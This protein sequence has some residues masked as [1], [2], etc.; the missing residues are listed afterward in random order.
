MGG[1][2]QDILIHFFV[3]NWTNQ[4]SELT[5]SYKPGLF[6]L[7][8]SVVSLL[9][10]IIPLISL[11]GIFSEFN[12]IPFAITFAENNWKSFQ[13]YYFLNNLKTFFRPIF[14]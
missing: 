7:M 14:Y 11:F 6:D 8:Q 12:I 10:L 5:F 1:M 2:V 4:Q 9:L 13:N 3:V